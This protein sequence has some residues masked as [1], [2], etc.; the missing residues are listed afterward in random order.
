[1]R[2]EAAARAPIPFADL[3]AQRRRL[4][5]RLDAAIARVLAHGRYIMGP[6]VA[7][8]EAQLAAFCGA[9]H[10]ITCASGTDA[11]LLGLMARGIGPGDAVLMPSFTFVATAEPVAW[12]GAVPV[13]VDVLEGTF[14]LDPES[15]ERGIRT[16]KA[17]GLHPHAAIAVDLFGQ[18]ADYKSIEA[19][20]ARHGLWLMADA[21]QSFGAT[22]GGRRV[23][24]MGAITATSFFP[25]KPLGCYGDGGCVFTDDDD[26]AEAM[27]SLRVHGQGEDKY[28]NVRIGVNARLDTLQAAILL[29]KLR[30]FADELSARRAVAARYDEG[31]RD[32]V[33][34]P[35]VAAETTSVWAQYTLVIEGG[36]RDGVASALRAK[37]IP[38]AVYYP[39]PLHQQTAYRHFPTA[40]DALP[41]S[42]QLSRQ[43]L[44]LPMHPY[45]EPATQA[46]II[47]ALRQAL[48][49]DRGI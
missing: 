42:E 19:I 15:L 23:G 45:L 12:L 14:N 33:E 22:Y 3:D 49:E 18:P 28:D 44:S 26:L 46:F 30:V 41:V 36:A 27:R 39:K 10:A 9:R 4:G 1:M 6:E 5:P 34:V 25:A 29:E 37:G 48:A 21:A 40:G 13:F 2:P 20:C 35:R 32:I 38:T 7:E 31:L 47:D 16:A 24:S 11:L 17:E 43:V 8:L